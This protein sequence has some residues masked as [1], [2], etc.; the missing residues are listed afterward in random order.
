MISFATDRPGAGVLVETHKSTLANRIAQAQVFLE[1]T[2]SRENSHPHIHRKMRET[3]QRRPVSL[4]LILG[5][6]DYGPGTS[7]KN[8]VPLIA[9]VYGV[10]VVTSDHGPFKEL[11]F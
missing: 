3:G 10:T 11:A 4:R 9:P 2:I 6:S 7:L 1:R 5:I 8:V